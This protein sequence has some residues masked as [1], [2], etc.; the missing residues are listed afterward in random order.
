M[1]TRAVSSLGHI[2]TSGPFAGLPVSL[3][4][5]LDWESRR[6]RRSPLRRVAEVPSLQSAAEVRAWLR[7]VI[8]RDPQEPL[9]WRNLGPKGYAVVLAWLGQPAPALDWLPPDEC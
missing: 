5:I 8:W 7:G 9:G 6:C 4:T 1:A 2:V 3:V